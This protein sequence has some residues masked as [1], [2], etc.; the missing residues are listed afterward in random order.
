MDL[1]NDFKEAVERTRY[2]NHRP[3]NQILLKLYALYKQA[4]SGDITEET[5][6]SA[7]DFKAAAKYEAWKELKGKSKEAC[8]KDY[9]HLVESLD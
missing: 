7:H 1:E 6:R 4:T 8:M 9:I 5:T 3:S 2:L